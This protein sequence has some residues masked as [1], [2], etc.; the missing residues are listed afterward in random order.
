MGQ[1]L[2]VDVRE[3]ARRLGLGRSLTYSLIVKGKL[4][5]VKIAGARRIAVAD[6]EAFVSRLREE[7]ANAECTRV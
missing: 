3:A 2:L 7:A 5:S 4:P 1:E 6:L